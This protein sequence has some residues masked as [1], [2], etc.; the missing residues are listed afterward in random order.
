MKEAQPHQPG[1]V[2]CVKAQGSQSL[3][4]PAWENL[5]R[6]LSERAFLFL[7][8]LSSAEF[9][10]SASERHPRRPFHATASPP[11]LLVPSRAHPPFPQSV[12]QEFCFSVDWLLTQIFASL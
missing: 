7:R 8:A 9:P 6:H 4:C 10:Q 2:Y 3:E 12:V 11:Q 1:F 5:A